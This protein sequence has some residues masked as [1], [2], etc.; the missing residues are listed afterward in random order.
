MV[1]GDEHILGVLASLLPLS[2]ETE[3]WR[4]LFVFAVR[5]DGRQ[6]ST[7]AQEVLTGSEM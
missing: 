6:M 7:T 2:A 1:G 3:V 5:P 4:K